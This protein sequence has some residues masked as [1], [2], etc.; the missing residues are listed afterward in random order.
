MYAGILFKG[1]RWPSPRAGM[2]RGLS[3]AQA[4]PAPTKSS[5]PPPPPSAAGKSDQ[6]VFEELRVWI[7]TEKPSR[8]DIKKRV[9]KLRQ[10]RTPR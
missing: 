4:L 9:E 10:E 3:Y 1:P 5:P 2:R 8:D 7:E 6:Q